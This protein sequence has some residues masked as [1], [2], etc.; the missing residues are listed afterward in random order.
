MNVKRR[1]HLRD[2]I[3]EID[4]VKEYEFIPEGHTGRP[5]II[6]QGEPI[7]VGNREID[8]KLLRNVGIGAGVLGAA[9]LGYY[10]YK[11]HKDK[12]KE[13]EKPMGRTSHNSRK[14][15]IKNEEINY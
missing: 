1:P 7:K 12:V 3:T 15:F 4:D 11:K 5:T 14:G 10:A 2:Y 9:G 13:E 6:K 8:K